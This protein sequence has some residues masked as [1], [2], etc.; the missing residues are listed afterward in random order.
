LKKYFQLKNQSLKWIDIINSEKPK[1]YS[2]HKNGNN[3]VLAWGVE[4]KIVQEKYNATKLNNFIINSKG[5]Y[6]FGYLGYDAKNTIFNIVG[7][8]ISQNEIPESIFFIPQ[9]VLILK[10]GLLTYFGTKRDYD[11]INRLKSKALIKTPS[12]A[13][14]FKLKAETSY[15][16]YIK[17]VDKVK[18][19]LKKGNIYE[20]NYCINF[21]HENSPINTIATFLNIEKHTEAPFSA[22]FSF[23]AVTIISGSPERFYNKHAD[24]IISQPIKGSAARGKTKAE[25][26]INKINLQNDSKEVSENLMIVDLV[27]NDIS[28][29]ATKNSVKVTELCEV[30]SFKSILQLI[31][32]VQAKIDSKL[33]FHDITKNLFPMGSMTGAPKYSA[34][35]IIDAIET[36][37]R[38][39]YSGCLGYI[40][41]TNNHD[42][43]VVIRSVVYNSSTNQ[44]SV[45]VGSA[46]TIKS[47]NAKEYL[48][49]KL[50]LAS[51]EKSIVKIN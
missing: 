31:S 4:Q 36:F 5:N 22:L 10:N 16:D 35:K 29:I 33:T 21:T 1:H 3:F 9:N 13:L 23:E 20:L 26:Q 2:L 18:E 40:T 48:E 49:C 32:T 43:N 8:Q 27:R 24:T 44:L 15:G 38:N 12:S 34:L 46:I 14:N 7:K 30:Y 37:K 50:K 28:K 11:R 41:P 51:I 47:D 45:S 19:E 25:D 42:F 17:N 39:I 6:V